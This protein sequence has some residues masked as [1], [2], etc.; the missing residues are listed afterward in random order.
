MLGWRGAS[1]GISRLAGQCGL[2]RLILKKRRGGDY[3]PA[4]ALA[5]FEEH[6]KTMPLA[7]QGK[8]FNDQALPK[9][10]RLAKN[11]CLSEEEAIDRILATQ[12]GAE[13]WPEAEVRST[14]ERIY[15]D[16]GEHVKKTPA[17]AEPD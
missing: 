9:A 13:R 15:A 5:R 2:R 7:G 6:L 10:V 1:L 11:A 12:V 17:W 4:D 16:D 14:V 8:G 3:D